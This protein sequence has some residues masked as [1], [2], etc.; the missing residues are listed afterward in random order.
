MSVKTVHVDSHAIEL[1][2]P[3][4][5]LFPGDGITKG[6]LID[7]YQRVAATMLPHVRQ[8]A[9]SMQRFPN[10]IAESGF[11]QKEAPDYFPDWIDRVM[12]PVEEKGKEQPQ[13]VCNNAA[14]LV[15][16]A[17][18]DCIT[19]HIWLSRTDSLHNPDRLIFDFDPASDDFAPIRK[20]A[21][22][23][24]QL[25]AD[26]GLTS[27]VMTTGSRGLHVVVPLDRSA[28]FDVVRAF[29]KDVADVLVSRNPTAFTTEVRKVA[30]Q[31]RLFVDYLRNSFAQTSVAPYSVRPK[32]GA[33]VA[34]PLDWDELA[35]PELSSQRYT[36]ANIFHRLAQ[37][38]DPWS[39]IMQ[40]GYAIGEARRLLDD[41]RSGA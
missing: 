5:V 8:R 35:A 13:V 19:P 3:D 30:R 16:L 38:G 1:S 22:S 25:L 15:Y 29:A 21:Q 18:Q 9:I 34:T 37:R 4:K 23:M 33:P 36:L 39:G 7:Y 28:A 2:H 31:G 27:F 26:L 40:R 6:E 10:G 14:T 41:L 11:Y 17:N 24:R 20:A 32:P 12:V